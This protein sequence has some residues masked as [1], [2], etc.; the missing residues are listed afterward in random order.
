M[1]ALVGIIIATVVNMFLRNSMFDFV[2]C[3]IGLG[4]FL[5]LTAYDTQKIKTSYYA[6]ASSDEEMSSKIIIIS[7]LGL[8]LDFINIFLR[9]LRLFGKR[10]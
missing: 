7:A 8:Y 6:I 2:L 3:I 10:K 1:Y 9:L 5:G 4:V